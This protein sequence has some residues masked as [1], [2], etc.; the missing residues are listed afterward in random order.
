MRG[1]DDF[2]HMALLSA[3]FM[4]L[5]LV[6]FVGYGLPAAPRSSRWPPGSRFSD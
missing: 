3:I 1:H 6:V 2:G 4:V 5:T